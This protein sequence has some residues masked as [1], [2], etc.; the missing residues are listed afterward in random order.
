MP[1][2]PLACRALKKASFPVDDYLEG[3]RRPE[4]EKM[5][6]YTVARSELPAGN[7]RL[8]SVI[9]TFGTVG[10]SLAWSNKTDLP[11]PLKD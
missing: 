2:S 8:L 10:V 6:D 9:R 4:Q 7:S 1:K 11:V 3:Q 5:A